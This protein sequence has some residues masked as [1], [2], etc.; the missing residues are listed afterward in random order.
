MLAEQDT[1]RALVDV[2]EGGQVRVSLPIEALQLLLQRLDA[3]LGSY[4]PIHFRPYFFSTGQIEDDE[5]RH[6]A[7]LLVLGINEAGELHQLAGILGNDNAPFTSHGSG[8]LE[9]M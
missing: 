9:G 1:A 3:G 8:V 5:G 4:S 7:Q 2:N 6:G